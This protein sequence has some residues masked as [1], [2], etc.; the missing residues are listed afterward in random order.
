WLETGA[1]FE[2]SLKD[3]EVPKDIQ[4][5]LL[6]NYAV[7]LSEKSYY[8]K[9]KVALAS[10]DAIR[11]IEDADFRVGALAAEN[12]LLEISYL[13]DEVP[14]LDV[15]IQAKEQITWLDL[16]G[17]DLSGTSFAPIAQLS[18]LTRL[19]LENTVTTDENVA[20]LINLKHLE[21]L[22]LHHSKVTD[23]CLE[24]LEK[25]AS[26]KRVYLWE[27]AVTQDAAETLQ[28]KRENLEINLGFSFASVVEEGENGNAE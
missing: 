18:N 21:S 3:Q 25:I 12:G 17:T 19:Q 7:D 11:A 6:E 22:N 26:L 14:N 2:A 20:G 9:V 15:L 5:L 4:F 8:E 24:S 16:G 28:S 23:N 10:E 27:T 1:S 13:G